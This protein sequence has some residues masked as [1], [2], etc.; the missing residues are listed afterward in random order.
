MF[1]IGGNF[2]YLEFRQD[3]KSIDKLPPAKFI[4]GHFGMSMDIPLY[5][6]IWSFSPD[7]QLVAKTSIGDDSEVILADVQVPLTFSC[8]ILPDFGVDLGPQIAYRVVDL[9]KIN[10]NFESNLVGLE[11]LDFGIAGGV[12]FRLNDNLMLVGRYFYGLRDLN[13]ILQ[14][15]KTFNR[16]GQISFLY[17]GGG[18]GY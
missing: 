14:N 8:Y 6:D 2:D 5:E 15:Q 1:K 12:R 17:S 7:I 13:T 10:G 3:D 18:R 11:K 9:T 16:S 4:G